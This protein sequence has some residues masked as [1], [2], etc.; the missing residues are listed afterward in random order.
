MNIITDLILKNI[1]QQTSCE[2][3]TINFFKFHLKN[4]SII[5]KEIT[6]P[7]IRQLSVLEPYVN[8]N[9]E[10]LHNIELFDNY[11]SILDKFNEDAM[12]GNV[13]HFINIDNIFKESI[14]Y[15]SILFCISEN[16]DINNH[17][18]EELD[19]FKINIIN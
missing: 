11:I 7:K 18:Q 3:Y 14:L 6:L 5:H 2:S 12:V 10:R 4:Y 17:S 1:S 8:I 9:R 16:I 13:M 15:D 19:L